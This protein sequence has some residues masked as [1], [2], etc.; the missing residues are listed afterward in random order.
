MIRIPLDLS[1]HCIQTETRRQYNRQLSICL[2]SP[3]RD[4]DAEKKLVLLKTA[5][6]TWDFSKLRAEHTALCGGRP[7]AVSLVGDDSGRCL[8]VLDGLTLDPG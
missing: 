3:E 1:S 4:N 8:L 6:E 5:L 7:H 2:K